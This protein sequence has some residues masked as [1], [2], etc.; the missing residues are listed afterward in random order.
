MEGKVLAPIA[1]SPIDASRGRG[2]HSPQLRQIRSI[3]LD[4]KQKADYGIQS[5]NLYFSPTD[6]NESNKEVKNKK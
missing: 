5:V 3:H 6:I 4:E 2:K 1:Y